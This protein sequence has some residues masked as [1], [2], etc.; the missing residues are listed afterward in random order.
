[1]LINP[2]LSSNPTRE[3]RLSLARKITTV[4]N[5][6]DGT[7]DL[8]RNIQDQLGNAYVVG[9]TGPPGV[10]KSTLI[11]SCIP[12]F[13]EL[14]KTVAVLAVDPSSQIS[15][16][17]ILGDRIRMSQHGTDEMVFIR[18]VAS[19]GHLGG[20]TATALNIINVI[21]ASGWDTI[22][23]ETVGAGQSEI[24]ISELAD[25]T[26]VVE[27]PGL[28]D[29]IQAVK[30]GLLETADIIAVNKADLPHS[31]LVI[32]DISDAIDLRHIDL[33]PLILKTVAVSGKGVSELVTEI[34]NHSKVATAKRN[35]TVLDRTR[36]FTAR[37][38]A[39]CIERQLIE[40][41]TPA[42]D[43]L[44]QRIQ[45]GEI[46]PDEIAN[47]FLSE[48]AEVPNIRNQSTD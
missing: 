39:E 38:V 32:S 34:I 48:I 23:V 27:S 26:V 14:G 43:K 37:V 12:I 19:R 3:T 30:A 20:L 13:R 46:S 47:R 15:G 22:I 33:K 25:T 29:D 9:F 7:K 17:A 42:I 21:D 24:E 1:M 45:S 40:L 5:N 36:K 28:G 10:G 2:L 11:D 35:R 41:Q 6:L 8:L 4:E 31:D 18:S 16:G 44:L